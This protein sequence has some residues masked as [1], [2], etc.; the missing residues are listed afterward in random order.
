MKSI[1]ILTH[2]GDPHAESVC[3]YFENKDV[4]YF[5]VDVDNLIGN[6]S[7]TFDSNSGLFLIS[8]T[9]RTILVDDQWNI[10]N[11]RMVDPVLPQDVP[12]ELEDIVFTETKKTL[13]GLLFSHKGKVVNRPQANFGA[14]NKIDQLRFV[15]G[16]GNGI[17]IPETLVTNNHAELHKFYRQ[18]PKICHKLQKVALVQEKGSDCTLV[19]YTNIL[20]EEHIQNADLIVRNPSF[21]QKYIEKKVELRI[22]ALENEVIGI[23]IHSQDSEQSKI[24]FRRYDFDNVTYE[25]VELP[26]HVEKF[27]KDLLNNYGLSFGEIDMILTPEEKY[28]FLELNPN[29]QWLWL[30]LKS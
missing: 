4:K 7:V 26:L 24:D 19:T 1:L 15:K 21:F 2:E 8:D 14:N 5:R 30:E 13:E 23:A 29:G 16:Y 9:K 10:W 17:Y 20:N 3:K 12:K 28:V 25:K 27:C 6:Y 11:R 22:T 18:H